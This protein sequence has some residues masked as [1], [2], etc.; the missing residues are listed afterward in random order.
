MSLIRFFLHTVNKE[1]CQIYC[2][3]LNVFLKKLL[4]PQISVDRWGSVAVS[5]NVSYC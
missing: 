1:F 4:V 5:L 2:T 3:E